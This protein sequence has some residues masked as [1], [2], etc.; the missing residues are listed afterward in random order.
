MP[1]ETTNEPSAEPVTITPAIVHTVREQWL[2]RRRELITA[3]DVAAILNCDPFRKPSDVYLQK[4]GAQEVAESEP[5]R[6]GRRLESAIAEAYGDATLRI[7]HA[8]AAPYVIDVHPDIP[9]LAATLDRRAEITAGSTPAPAP[10]DGVV[11]LK[12]TA[13]A[14]S[15]D[16]GPP[17]AYQL[18]AQVQMSCASVQWG[19]LAAFVGLFRPVVWV[20]LKFDREL[21]EV[22]VPRLE[23]FRLCVERREP[24]VSPEWFSREAIRRLWPTEDPAQKI[25]LDDKALALVESWETLKDEEADACRRKEDTEDALRVLMRDATTGYLPDG[26]SLTLRTTKATTI[27]EHVRAPFRVLRRFIPRGLQ[28]A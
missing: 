23:A 21:I 28:R 13:F 16:D 4:I 15:W 22:I 8:P 7:V 20:D 14:E 1:K 25:A 3:S 26:T 24:P 17:I 5:M 9:W 18:Q 6:W 2:M 27:A 10:G 11:E 19:S 12:A